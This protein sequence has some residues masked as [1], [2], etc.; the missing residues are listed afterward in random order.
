MTYSWGRAVGSNYF[1]RDYTVSVYSKQSLSITKVSDGLDSVKYMDGRRHLGDD[2][3]GFTETPHYLKNPD[4]V[5]EPATVESPI[6]SLYDAVQQ[7]S[8]LAGLLHHVAANPW[9]LFVWVHQEALPI[10]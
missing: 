8:S 5:V 10:F 4:P 6:L 9:V 7:S 2:W 1:D 3:S